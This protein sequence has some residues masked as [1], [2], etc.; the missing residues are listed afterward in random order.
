MANFFDSNRKIRPKRRNT[1]GTRPITWLFLT[2]AERLGLKAGTHRVHDPSHGFFLGGKTQN[3]ATSDPRALF[4]CQNRFTSGTRPVL[5]LFRFSSKR[6]PHFSRVPHVDRLHFFA[7]CF[8]L[9]TVLVSLCS[10]HV[11]SETHIGFAVRLFQVI[12]SGT[13]R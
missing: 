5:A 2:P 4:R 8:C 11:S 13:R 6:R 3:R 1:S 10:F 9:T 12:C 7:V